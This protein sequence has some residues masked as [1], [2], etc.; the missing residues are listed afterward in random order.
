MNNLSFQNDVPTLLFMT[1]QHQCNEV[2]W[3][4]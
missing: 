2:E 4:P 3:G 1:E